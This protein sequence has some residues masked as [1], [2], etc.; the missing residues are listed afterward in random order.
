V[1]IAKNQKI[2][3]YPAP[4]IRQL[5]RETVGR[6]ITLRY[7][8]E[9]L[10]CSES[11]AIRV[12]NDLRNDGFVDSVQGHF[13]P[14]TKGSALAMATAAPP[15]RRETAERLIAAVIERA[16]AVNADSQWAYRIGLMVLFGSCV[17]HT[18][19]P[20]DVDIACELL[21]RWDGER[22]RE[23]EQI[24][25]AAKS[26]RFRNLSEWATWPKLEVV[27]FLKSRARGLSI[28]QLEDWI[29]QTANHRVLFRDKPAESPEKAA[30]QPAPIATFEAQSIHE[31]CID[32]E[33][34]LH[35]KK[36]AR[37]V[38]LG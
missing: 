37:P 10:H 12:L 35:E 6:P 5:M 25:R 38:H 36:Y 9:I 15:L 24:R 7:V 16:H 33:K 13:E 30:S 3:G 32:A 14:S 34:R 28:H 26:E 18:D 19:R 4:R 17:C 2:A 23:Q 27:R 29:L 1:R 20:N 8:R 21:P 22:Q 31:K 11:A